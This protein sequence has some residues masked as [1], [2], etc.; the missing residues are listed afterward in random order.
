MKSLAP[1]DQTP[2]IST[3]KRKDLEAGSA[4]L[5]TWQNNW[6][7]LHIAN[8]RN[9][10]SANRCDKLIQNL[11]SKSVQKKME[12]VSLV[13]EMP[14]VNRGIQEI[15]LKLGALESLLG[16]VEIGLLALEDTIDAREMQEKQLEQRFQLAMYQE[17]RKAEFNE[18]ATRL[19]SDY[20]RKKKRK[21]SEERQQKVIFK[22]SVTLSYL[23]K[24]Q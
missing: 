20:E 5:E 21:M 24:S 7:D 10:K 14:K 19:Q 9:A 6:E 17:R 15:M 22:V 23:E 3:A 18:L 4:L 16:D 8:E 11:K 1:N 2:G 12:V 13:N